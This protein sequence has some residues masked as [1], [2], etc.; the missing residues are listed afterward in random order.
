M[1]HHRIF[2]VSDDSDTRENESD[3]EKAQRLH[4]NE[5]RADMRL[6]TLTNDHF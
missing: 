5:I 1:E 6:L 4:R 2:I 3:E